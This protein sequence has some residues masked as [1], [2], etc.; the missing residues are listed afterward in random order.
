VFRD[1]E[2]AFAK[3]IDIVTYVEIEAATNRGGHISLALNG[4]KEVLE[5]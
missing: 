5:I 2:I 1:D 3:T 4:E